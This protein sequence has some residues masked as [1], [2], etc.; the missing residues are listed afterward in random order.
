IT[1]I[2]RSRLRAIGDVLPIR[3]VERSLICRLVVGSNVFGL[4][5]RGA[6]PYIDWNDPQIV[7][8]ADGFDWIV[9]RGVANLLPIRR[10]RIELL[11]AESERWIIVVSRFEVAGRAR[12]TTWAGFTQLK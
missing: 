9:I 8:G 10:T 11:S 4:N 12:M 2:S 7:A 5:G 1:L 3:R 6:R